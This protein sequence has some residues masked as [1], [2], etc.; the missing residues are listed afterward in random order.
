MTLDLAQLFLDSILDAKSQAEPK[1]VAYDI[2]TGN[3]T[4]INSIKVEANAQFYP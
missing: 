4:T 3:P 2:S 1:M